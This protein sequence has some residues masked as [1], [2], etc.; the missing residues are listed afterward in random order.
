M[1]RSPRGLFC[2]GWFALTSGGVLSRYALDVPK[3]FV[4]TFRLLMRPEELLE[5][6]VLIYCTVPSDSGSGGDKTSEERKLAPCRLRILNLLKKWIQ[7]HRYDFA[8]QALSNLTADF[9]HNTI[10]LTV[11]KKRCRYVFLK[12]KKGVRATCGKSAK[13]AAV[14]VVSYAVAMSRAHLAAQARGRAPAI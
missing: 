10:K 5:R 11:K 9:L 3:I 12:E 4:T 1:S 7:M 8:D 6:L 2:F 14:D 13:H